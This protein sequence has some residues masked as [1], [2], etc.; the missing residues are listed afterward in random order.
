MDMYTYK[1]I[2]VERADLLSDE[3]DFRIHT[4][5]GP[6]VDDYI[7]IYIYIYRYMYINIE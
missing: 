7:Y 3:D 2:P 4:G 1:Y 5:G 6:T